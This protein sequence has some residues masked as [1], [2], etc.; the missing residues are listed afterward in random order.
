VVSSVLALEQASI[1]ATLRRP[2][3]VLRLVD[4]GLLP[5]GRSGSSVRASLD[6]F[7]V[8]LAPLDRIPRQLR[9]VLNVGGE[10]ADT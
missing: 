7:D 10:A 8:H 3:R 9:V 2:T 5:G 4:V 6:T 1:A